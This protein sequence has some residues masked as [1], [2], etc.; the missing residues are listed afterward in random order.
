MGGDRIKLKAYTTILNVEYD[1]DY[2]KCLVS[3]A[4]TILSKD[5]IWVTPIFYLPKLM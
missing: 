4:R 5:F 2:I 3:A 1:M